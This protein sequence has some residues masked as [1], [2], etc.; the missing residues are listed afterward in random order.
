MR[1]S[2][3]RIAFVYC[4]EAEFHLNPGLARAWHRHG[5][6]LIVPSAGQNKRVP[7]FGALDARTGHVATMIT[8]RKCSDDFI[9]FLQMLVDHV[10]ADRR[11]VYLF[12]DNC[13]IHHT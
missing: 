12:L 7:V 13:S 5:E 3:G 1:A 4:D 6:R 10:Y 8:T 11:H 9:A 2:R